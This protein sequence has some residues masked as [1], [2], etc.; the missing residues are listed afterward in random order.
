MIQHLDPRAWDRAVVRYAEGWATGDRRPRHSFEA[1]ALRMYLRLRTVA[2]FRAIRRGRRSVESAWKVALA[3][4]LRPGDVVIDG[5]ANVGLVST[6]AAWIVGSG[7][8]VHSFEPSPVV[9]EHLTTRSERLDLANV[10]VVNR[11]LGR[12]T[13]HA[14]LHEY[15]SGRGGASSLRPSAFHGI[16]HD[17]ESAVLITSIDEYAA[18]VDLDRCRLV[19]LDVEGSELDAIEG[20]RDLIARQRP[21]LFVEANATALG[22]FGATVQDLVELIVGQGYSIW[23]WRGRSGGFVRVSSSADVPADAERDDFLCL[24]P[25]RHGD[26]VERCRR[27]DPSMTNIDDRSPGRSTRPDVL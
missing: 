14:V 11:G 6:A 13:S 7:G 17:R 16:A 15:D 12:E 5:G 25:A 10:R 8:E 22:A 9:V 2:G 18:D 4:S 21:V 20:A 1:T 26:V 24:D 3:V 19:K 23:S 27:L